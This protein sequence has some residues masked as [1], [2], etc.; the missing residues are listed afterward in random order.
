MVTY[1][2]SLSFGRYIKTIRREKGISLQEVSR[3][4]KIG[5]DTLRLIEKEDHDRLPAEVFVKGF[6][7][8]YAKVVGAD[9]D[10]AI[11]RYLSDYQAY[12]AAVKRENDLFRSGARFWP[13]FVLAFSL[14]GC[15][16]A[17]TLYFYDGF[18]L[19]PVDSPDETPLKSSEHQETPV[20]SETSNSEPETD[21]NS[22]THKLLLKV[23]A[24]KKTWIKVQ[25][26]GQDSKEYRLNT[27][28][29]LE[30]EGSSGY[31]ILMGDAKG[32]ELT[33]DDKPF[34]IFGKEGQTVTV[35]IP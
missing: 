20:A 29:H 10:V 21:L 22:E 14:L 13:R 3:K 16:I 9:G 6:L 5:V 35:Q 32:V 7:R 19:Q 24:L 34:K 2:N 1:K 11:D 12:Q 33:L 4:T 27:G 18:Q 23:V 17:L 8:A 25:I 31:N 28:D 30:L 26:D 15:I